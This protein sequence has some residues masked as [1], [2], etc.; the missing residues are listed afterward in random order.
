[1]GRC[2]ARKVNLL[3]NHRSLPPTPVVITAASLKGAHRVN[4]LAVQIWLDSR[5]RFAVVCL[6]IYVWGAPRICLQ[7]SPDLEQLRV[8][9]GAAASRGCSLRINCVIPKFG[10][11][12][13]TILVLSL[14]IGALVPGSLRG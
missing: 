9:A 6:V 11:Q 14:F 13:F 10:F 4:T 5:L 8:S 1:L 7:K 12:G 3:R 2:G